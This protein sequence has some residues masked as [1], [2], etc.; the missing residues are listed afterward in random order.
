VAALAERHSP[1][2][3]KH[4]DAAAKAK[5]HFE[6]ALAIDPNYAQ[7]WSGLALCYYVLALMGVL[8]Y[9]E[10]TDRIHQ[11]AEKALAID[12]SDSEAHLVLAMTAGVLN[13]DWERRRGITGSP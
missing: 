6:Q 12:A 2:G 5:E 13:Y 1:S 8:P 9:G 4:P 11:I 10:A 3:E 7:A